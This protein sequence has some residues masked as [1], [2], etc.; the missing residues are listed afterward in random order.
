[1]QM[2]LANAKVSCD[3]IDVEI[4]LPQQ[5]VLI[6]MKLTPIDILILTIL[7]E[8]IVAL[9]WFQFRSCRDLGEE[10]REERER[11]RGIERTLERAMLEQTG[12]TAR[13]RRPEGLR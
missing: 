13:M 7:I 9:F 4:D 5:E 3:T 2:G 10:T 1:M 8:A 11:S 6:M 12:Q